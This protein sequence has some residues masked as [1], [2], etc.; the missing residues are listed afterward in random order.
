L[1]LFSIISPVG[2]NT[3]K[4]LPEGQIYE[5]CSSTKLSELLLIPSSILLDILEIH[6]DY[7]ALSLAFLFSLIVYFLTGALIGWIIGKIKSKK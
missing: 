5:D 2:C 1:I 4:P 7:L 6:N 3:S